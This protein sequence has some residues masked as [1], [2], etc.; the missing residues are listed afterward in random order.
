MI[1]EFS[2]DRNATLKKMHMRIHNST[3]AHSAS[4]M[5]GTPSPTTFREAVLRRKRGENAFDINNIVIPY[6]IASSTRVEK[7]QYK[8]ILTPRYE[9][10]HGDIFAITEQM[11]M[12]ED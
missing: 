7:L 11:E 3:S 2:R 1:A 5:R 4:Y 12:F 6:N 9:Q 10:L 8:E